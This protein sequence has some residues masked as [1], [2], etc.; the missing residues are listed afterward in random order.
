MLSRLP[1][2]A[3]FLTTA[4]LSGLFAQA[5]TATM[6]GTV[7]DTSGAVIAGAKLD[8]RSVTKNETQVAFSD[9]KGEFT[10]PNLAPGNYEVVVSRTASTACTRPGPRTADRPDRAPG[11]P[12]GSRVD[13]ID[14]EV[15]ATVP[16]INTESCAKGE[17]MVT[18]EVVEMPLDGRDF[19]DLVPGAHPASFAGV[20]G[21]HGS[22]FRTS[23][24]P[25]PTTPT[26][27]S[28]ASTIRT[29]ARRRPG[30]SQHRC[31]ARSSECRPAAIPPSSADSPAAS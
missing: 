1:F 18:Q 16:L 19:T 11:V 10:I 3:A 17:V 15:T 23:M 2:R 13:R 30:P 28:T 31:P 27:P 5:P 12:T 25:V 4:A 9:Q 29:P 26:S 22:R 8:V 7:V 6:V 24:A 21:A 14:V 20:A